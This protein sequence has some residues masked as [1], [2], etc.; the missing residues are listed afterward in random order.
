MLS[1]PSSFTRN[2]LADQE[3]PKLLGKNLGDTL[4]NIGVA[5]LKGLAKKSETTL[6]SI[7]NGLDF[8]TN[9]NYKNNTN[10]KILNTTSTFILSTSISNN[11]LLN[12]G[13]YMMSLNDITAENK[14]VYENAFKMPAEVLESIN[15]YKYVYKK[16]GVPY[17]MERKN[18]KNKDDKSSQLSLVTMQVTPSLFNPLFAVPAHGF[19]TSK[20]VSD[21]YNKSG[22]FPLN[23]PIAIDGHIIDYSNYYQL[24]TEIDNPES[25]IKDAKNTV[26]KQTDG[27]VNAEKL[28]NYLPNK[29]KKLEDIN[30]CSIK[31][32]VELSKD[33]TI[34][35]SIY[36]QDVNVKKKSP[37]GRN[38]YRYADFMYCK[39]LGKVS[40]NHMITLRR[41]T[42]PI[43]DNINDAYDN[44]GDPLI[45]PDRGRLISWFGTGDNKLEDICKYNYVAKWEEFNSEIER[46]DSKEENH[47]NKMFNALSN[48]F[49]AD[50]IDVFKAGATRN[51]NMFI[52]YFIGNSPGP[53][54]G[55]SAYGFRDPNT[56]WEPKDTIRSTHK[57]S[58]KLEFNQ[59]ITLKFSYSLRYYNGINPKAAFLD[60]LGNI[61]EVTYRRGRFWGGE[62]Y[63][64]GPRPNTA[65]WKTINSITDK[66]EAYSTEKGAE[67]FSA[68]FGISDASDFIN[69]CTNAFSGIGNFFGDIANIVLNGKQPDQ[70]LEDLKAAASNPDNQKNLAKNAISMVFANL[71]NKLGRPE[72]YATKSLLSGDPVGLWHLTVGNP[73]NPILSI[74][75]LIL[76]GADIQHSG[77]LGIDD[78][79]TEL[80]VTVNLKHA[81]PRDAV[82]ISTMYTKGKT[83]IYTELSNVSLSNYFN[84]LE[85]SDA[86]R[87]YK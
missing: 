47:D 13:N 52:N 25:P 9:R 74:G 3:L 21:L 75:N 7:K 1:F 69:L 70:A 8:D 6:D 82:E 28:S 29:N 37:L 68:I 16:Y 50:Y 39:D 62:K 12:G 54:Y 38:T 60:L 24:N 65:T 35:G 80:S 57:Y 14:N 71:K 15:M 10:V 11:E 42:E 78:F 17:Q 45:L 20:Q 79:P 83:P 4:T 56:L 61:L 86:Q 31:T 22:I 84:E 63:W 67:A 49:N 44:N 46:V 51:T 66:L 48:I 18:G 33:S 26:E 5:A 76:T 59:E 72:I 43:M 87:G 27:N 58:G 53:Y 73:R 85:A 32:L 41:F 34:E 30:D 2:T 81:R 40:N 64:V 23:I 19:G 36:Q 55:D 77:P